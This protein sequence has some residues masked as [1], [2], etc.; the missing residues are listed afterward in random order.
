MQGVPDHIT[1]DQTFPAAL[2]GIMSAEQFTASVQR[3][4]QALVRS[5]GYIAAGYA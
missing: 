5:P 1:F 2:Q 3:I 4:N